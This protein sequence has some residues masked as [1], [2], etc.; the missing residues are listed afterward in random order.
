MPA[1]GAVK[2]LVMAMAMLV[3]LDIGDAHAQGRG[4]AAAGL[5]GRAGLVEGRTEAH[6]K[7]QRELD[8]WLRRLV[9]RF[10]VTGSASV[11]GLADCVA[12]GTGPGV[13]CVVSYGSSGTPVRDAPTVTLYGMD[14]DRQAIRYLEVNGRSLAKEGLGRLSGS[15]LSFRMEC[16]ARV[17][18]ERATTL[19]QCERELQVYAAPNGRHVQISDISKQH[20]IPPPP[21]P[22]PVGRTPRR[23]PGSAASRVL[24][25][26]FVLYL[27]RVPSQ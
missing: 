27:E 18:I 12:I 25:S 6:A 2:P 14:P 7:K 8:A 26:G 10:R 5:K 4:T 23:P 19:L 16:L 1:S 22:S 21:P 15:T 24:S 3:S 9:G 11:E 13:H 17:P 20:F